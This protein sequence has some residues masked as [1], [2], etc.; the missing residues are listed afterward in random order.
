MVD[1]M[2]VGMTRRGITSNKNRETS[3]AEG[4]LQNELD[5]K[6]THASDRHTY[7]MN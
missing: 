7:N 2:I 3:H 6:Q 4:L 5:Q 1:T